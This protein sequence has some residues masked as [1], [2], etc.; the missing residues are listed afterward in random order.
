M[1]ERM[2]TLAQVPGTS[3]T[4][5]TGWVLPF[6]NWFTARAACA[7]CLIEEALAL[8]MHLLVYVLMLRVR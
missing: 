1:V 7:A 3:T 6:A 2:L 5:S 8:H 4:T